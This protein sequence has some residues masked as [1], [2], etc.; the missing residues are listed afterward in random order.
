MKE[1]LQLVINMIA[2]PEYT[3]LGTSDKTDGIEE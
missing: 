3:G 1:F 2:S